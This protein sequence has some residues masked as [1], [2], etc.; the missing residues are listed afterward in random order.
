[1]SFLQDFPDVIRSLIVPYNV[2][3]SPRGDYSLR[4]GDIERISENL[5]LL[6]GLI[7]LRK[8]L[9]SYKSSPTKQIC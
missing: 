1:M 4:P 6:G 3:V 8:Y 5:L 9:I 2:W 7:T